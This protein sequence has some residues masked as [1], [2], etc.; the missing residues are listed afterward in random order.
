MLS[1][2]E[3]T[4][5]GGPRCRPCGH[6]GTLRSLS[7]SVVERSAPG[8]TLRL[9]PGG[10]AAVLRAHGVVAVEIRFAPLRAGLPA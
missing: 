10:I 9:R 7:R 1:G 6:P 4:G 8:P 5:V 3:G 2:G